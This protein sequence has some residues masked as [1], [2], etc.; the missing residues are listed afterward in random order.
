[1]ALYSISTRLT[2]EFVTL[3][4][5]DSID[6]AKELAAKRPIEGTWRSE[7][8]PGEGALTHWIST[9]VPAHVPRPAFDQLPD[10]GVQTL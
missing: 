1:M 9:G 5:A 2:I 6:A 8:P 3:V 4:R 7:L 10:M